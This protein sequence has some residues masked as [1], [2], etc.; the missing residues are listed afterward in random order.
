[1]LRELHQETLDKA[2]SI[3]VDRTQA[4]MYRRGATLLV[5]V[6]KNADPLRC[7]VLVSAMFLMQE[8]EPSRFVSDVGFW[9][10]LGLRFAFLGGDFGSRWVQTRNVAQKVYRS[11][12]PDILQSLA[13]QV[14][15]VYAR[16]IGAS[17]KRVREAAARPDELRMTI[18]EAMRALG[19]EVRQR[20]FKPRKKRA[21]RPLDAAG[22][23][24]AQ[25]WAKLKAD[26]AARTAFIKRA[27]AATAKGV[28]A[29]KARQAA[30]EA[31]GAV[32]PKPA[33]KSKQRK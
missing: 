19:P 25:Y 23:Y 33:K 8:R 2:A 14:R 21:R 31:A 12:N 30:A 20:I 22:G 27:Q 26:P 5:H 18:D 1:L 16:W 10:Q 15:V 7:A 11:Y 6:L 17:L 24:L 29:R 9:H 32:P 3:A 4:K 28:A 13:A